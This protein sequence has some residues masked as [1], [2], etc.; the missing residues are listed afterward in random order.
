MEANTELHFEPQKEGKQHSAPFE[1]ENEMFFDVWL[2][3]IRSKIPFFVSPVQIVDSIVYKDVVDEKEQ[4]IMFND[5]ND[6]YDQCY[7]CMQL[8]Y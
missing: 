1:K 7:G 5:D 6:N 8:A 4:N 2:V 3:L